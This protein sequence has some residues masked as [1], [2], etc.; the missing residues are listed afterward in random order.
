[1]PTL[2]ERLTDI[3]L[4]D[5]KRRLQESFAQTL[6]TTLQAYFMGPWQL[7][8]EEL[9]RQLKEQVDPGLLDYLLSQVGWS[10][11]GGLGYAAD[12]ETERNRAVNESIRLYKY[13]PLAQWSI[14]LWSGWGLGDNVTVKPNDAGAVKV[15]DEFWA[16]ERN[17]RLFATDRIHEL[18]HWLLVKG[19]RFVSFYASEMDGEVTAGLIQP[20]EVTAIITNPEDSSEPW[21]YKRQWTP[22][23]QN[24]KTLFYADWQ[25]FFRDD[26]EDDLEKRWEKVK[27]AHADI[28]D[29]SER[30]DQ[31][32]GLQEQLG[33]EVLPGTGVCLLHIPHNIKDEASLWGWPIL[34]CA[35]YYLGAHKKFTEDRL[36]VAAAKAMFVRRYQ[37][38]GGSRQQRS[39]IDDV[40]SNLS[41][42]QLTDTNPPAGAGSSEFLNKA[43]D[44]S[45]L[46]MSTG[47]SDAKTDNEMFAW[48]AL[49]GTGLFPTS[50]GLDTARWATAL[51]MDKAQSMLFTGYQTFWS[52]QWRK[53]V[54]IVL[55][56][57]EWAGQGAYEDKSAEVST[58]TFSLADFPAVAKTIGLLVKDAITPMIDNGTIP[59]EAGREIEAT[60]LRINLQALGVSNAQE[61]TDAKKWQTMA[62]KEEAE[63]PEP[64][65]LPPQ[66]GQQLPQPEGG[67]EP[68]VPA[69]LGESHIPEVIR[70]PCPLCANE[71]ALYYEGHKGLLV[72]AACGKTFDPAIE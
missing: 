30:A 57:Q 15:W 32:N 39:L 34:T 63:K 47:A 52:A 6:D 19:N 3:F 10:V 56:F 71:E 67:E 14:W 29:K 7:P 37:H 18:S 17:A 25:T 41:R 13:S 50:A 2:K 12:T 62:D 31:V 65:P 5:E 59:A 8:P 4:G 46:P 16:A 20:A 55:S 44:A 49:L 1:M 40:A 11:M 42:T 66:P 38:S 45:D 43:I 23:G 70:R 26:L 21:F 60:L 64:P 24:Q 53:M 28:D 27:L 58:D 22:T 72:C 35:Q 68:P 36:T 61:M 9:A 54:K 69:E 33:G 48:V 51:E